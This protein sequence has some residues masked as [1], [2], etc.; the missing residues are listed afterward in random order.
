MVVSI[1]PFTPKNCID[2]VKNL[3][4][5]WKQIDSKSNQS[6]LEERIN[7]VQHHALQFSESPI[8]INMICHLCKDDNFDIAPF[9]QIVTLVIAVDCIIVNNSNKE[10]G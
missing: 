1:A 2:L 9:V 6:Q 7:L 10:N 4:T 8:L 5:Q 3:L